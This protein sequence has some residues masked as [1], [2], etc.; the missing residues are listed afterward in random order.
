MW[1]RSFAQRLGAT[2]KTIYPPCG[3]W[4]VGSRNA[5]GL[6]QRRFHHLRRPSRWC[7]LPR[8]RSCTGS[9]RMRGES[10]TAN[11]LETTWATSPRMTFQQHDFFASSLV[12]SKEEFRPSSSF[13]KWM[14]NSAYF[15]FPMTKRTV[16]RSVTPPRLTG[17]DNTRRQRPTVTTN[18]ESF[19]P[20]RRIFSR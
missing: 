19:S 7:R 5:R 6:I 4:S 1:R 20:R 17:T 15:V 3:N 13:F 11:S 8:P 2:R 18:V 14:R 10:G 12:V 9:I 16:G